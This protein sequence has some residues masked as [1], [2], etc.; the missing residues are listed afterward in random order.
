MRK[1]PQTSANMLIRGGFAAGGLAM[2]L[3]LSACGH[4]DKA[5]DPASADNVEIPAEE[6][7]S[8]LPP[9]AVPV[10]DSADVVADSA[11]SGT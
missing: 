11:V 4:A 3:V 5:S 2:V 10:P 8:G 9:A 1:F 6:A 7:L